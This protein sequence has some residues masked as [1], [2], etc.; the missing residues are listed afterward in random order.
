MPDELNEQEQFSELRAGAWL[1]LFIGLAGLGLGIYHLRSGITDAF[2]V[3]GPRFKTSDELEAERVEGM[4]TKD[5]DNDGLNDYE[6]SF[7]FKTSPY[8]EDSD[9]DGDNDRVELAAGQNPNCPK[10]TDC[11]IPGAGGS[12]KPVPKPSEL[13]GPGV[14]DETP[15]DQAALEQLLNPDADQIRKILIEAGA[16]EADLAG[17]DDA[18]LIELYQQS[19]AEAQA[20]EGAGSDETSN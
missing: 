9:S 1:I 18:T 5:T 14:S 7:V 10:G 13:F 8:L 2:V 15:I 12:L 4:K 17:I 16:S 11:G 20:T 19:L 3:E 6:E